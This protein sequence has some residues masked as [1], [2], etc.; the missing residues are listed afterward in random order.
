VAGTADEGEEKATA[1]DDDSKRQDNKTN[2]RPRGVNSKKKGPKVRVELGCRLKGKGRGLLCFWLR[3]V[4]TGDARK[5]KDERW[6]TAAW[7][8]H[9]N[10]QIVG[11]EVFFIG[12]RSKSAACDVVSGAGEQKQKR[13]QKT[14]TKIVE[15]S[16][17]R[18]EIE[19]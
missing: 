6:R 12:S 8:E 9:R 4:W 13:E 11:G 17:N 16:I 5:M 7:I 15:H 14:R 1:W 19:G 18:I 2:E 3:V 10:A